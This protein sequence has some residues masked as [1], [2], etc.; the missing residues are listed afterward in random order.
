V[1]AIRTVPSL[2]VVGMGVE[3]RAFLVVSVIE[4]GVQMH[5]LDEPRQHDR[6]EGA[7]EL[8]VLVV[9][10]LGHLFS[11]CSRVTAMFRSAS[12]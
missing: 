2:H 4:L 7:R 12:S 10:V 9:D 3:I 11:V 1:S 6:R 5:R 8:A